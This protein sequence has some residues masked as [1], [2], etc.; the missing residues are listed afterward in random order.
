MQLWHALSKTL[1]EKCGWGLAMDR[2]ISMV[3]INAG[4]VMLPDLS[5]A[6]PYLKGAAEMYKNGVFVTVDLD[7]LV[8]AHICVYEDV[9]SYGRYLCFNHVINQTQD[10]LH[11]AKIFTPPSQFQWY[12]FFFF[13][14]GYYF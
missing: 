6:N 7:F 13:L 3:T 5:I 2:E 14:F 8:N 10:A 12:L 9:S 4:L 1:A 11:L